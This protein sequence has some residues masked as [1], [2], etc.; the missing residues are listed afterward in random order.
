MLR[1][2]ISANVGCTSTKT[3][4]WFSCSAEDGPLHSPEAQNT[5]RTLDFWPQH[6]K[7]TATDPRIRRRRAQE[8]L[9]I[10]QAHALRNK[11]DLVPKVAG[12][13]VRHQGKH[14]KR[15]PLTPY[16]KRFQASRDEGLKASRTT[17]WSTRPASMY[18]TAT[19]KSARNSGHKRQ[20]HHNN[21]T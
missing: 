8:K 11:M 20:P 6:C 16:S 21:G 12:K 18:D 7:P 17:V 5:S 4:A 3:L 14:K 2:T 1:S 10:T 9:Q 15:T 13:R 19:L